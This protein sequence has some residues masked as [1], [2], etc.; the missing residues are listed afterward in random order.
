[1]NQIHNNINQFTMHD[2]LMPN[3]E[4]DFLQ[5]RLKNDNS[6]ID[7]QLTDLQK[8]IKND[9]SDFAN[10]IQF[11]IDQNK[12][13]IKNISN[14]SVLA[15]TLN[16]IKNNI[17]DYEIYPELLNSIFDKFTEPNFY[18]TPIN[19]CNYHK[20]LI[21]N[22]NNI[23]NKDQIATIVKTVDKK[24]KTNT[25]F[26]SYIGLLYSIVE[27][28]NL[29]AIARA[30]KLMDCL[31]TTPES[32]DTIL[33]I[34]INLLQTSFKN[35]NDFNNNAI[36]KYFKNS[37]VPDLINQFNTDNPNIYINKIKSFHVNRLSLIEAIPGLESEYFDDFLNI[38]ISNDYLITDHSPMISY[39]YY[40]KN[41]LITFALNHGLNN[42]CFNK[43]TDSDKII[44]ALK[45]KFLN[46]TSE[47]FYYDTLKRL[48]QLFQFFKSNTDLFNKLLTTKPNFITDIFNKYIELNQKDNQY[49]PM[50][51]NI[52]QLLNDELIKLCLTNEL[53]TLELLKSIGFN[54]AQALKQIDSQND[55][56]ILM[57]TD[58]IANN[59]DT[60]NLKTHYETIFKYYLFYQKTYYINNGDLNTLS[61][62]AATKFV[63]LLSPIIKKIETQ[64]ALIEICKNNLSL[65]QYLLDDKSLIIINRFKEE[66]D[67]KKQQELAL[68]KQLE[69][70]NTIKS[71]LSIDDK[72]DL[73]FKFK[74]RS[75]YQKN[76]NCV[77]KVKN[78]LKTLNLISFLDQI[79]NLRKILSEDDLTSTLKD[80]LN[81]Y[82]MKGGR[83]E[84]DTN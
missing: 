79:S 35:S 82:E 73:F 55:K 39:T 48:K 76:K 18:F 4:Y 29:K 57:I 28:N 1:M 26:K 72:E 40:S 63:L 2:I 30:K 51:D 66:L 32:N 8:K 62:S 43:S 21:T 44:D 47:F 25:V 10:V 65:S 83:N 42:A 46:N 41:E 49:P 52:I 84:S 14:I 36:F 5:T 58:L 80:F 9:N 67:L 7:Y 68:Q 6:I 59:T 17:S 74:Y 11:G 13:H 23:L 60:N 61:T 20:G 33:N 53:F 70:E 54:I 22:L 50:D 19:H 81:N 12:D 77:E 15:K 34:Y 78:T 75:M 24:Y 31:L 38:F 3:L 69:Y 64:D 56:E 37:F 27:Y 71:F 16:I 45:N